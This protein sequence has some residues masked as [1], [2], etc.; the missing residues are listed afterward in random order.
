MPEEPLQWGFAL[1]LVAMGGH[2]LYSAAGCDGRE[3]GP[4]PQAALSKHAI[5]S[6]CHGGDGPPLTGDR[7]VRG[8]RAPRARGAGSRAADSGSRGSFS[9]YFIYHQPLAEKFSFR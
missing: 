1:F 6:S 9:S 4:R 2:K 7:A 5:C 8:R 3:T